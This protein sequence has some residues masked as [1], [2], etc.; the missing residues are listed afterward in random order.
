MIF[1]YKENKIV[2]KNGKLVISTKNEKCYAELKKNGF[3]TYLIQTL[4]NFLLSNQNE[5]T[6]IDNKRKLENK[7][8]TTVGFCYEE[9]VR[10]NYYTYKFTL[11]GLRSYFT[12]KTNE[13]LNLNSYYLLT[14]RIIKDSFYNKKRTTLENNLCYEE[15][16]FDIS[17]LK[18]LE[19]EEEV[20]VEERPR[21]ELH[22]HTTFSQ[23]DAFITSKQ[24]K[25]YFDK[26][27]LKTLAITDHGIPNSF[28][29]SIKSFSKSKD[30][31]VI[32]AIELYVVDDKK[33]NITK[34]NWYEQFDSCNEQL[35]IL[36]ERQEELNSFIEDKNETIEETKLKQNELKQ[37]VSDTEDKE[38][39]KELKVKA[40]SLREFMLLQKNSLTKLKTELKELKIKI[41]QYEEQKLELSKSE[42][43][44]GDATRFHVSIFVKSKDTVYSDKEK[45][46]EFDYNPGIYEL[47]KAI[48]KSFTET[49]G[50][51]VLN[52]FLGKRNIVCLSDLEKLKETGY[53]HISG[54]CSLGIITNYL[55]EKK[56]YIADEYAYLFDSIEL[57]P[58]TNNYY[59][60]SKEEYP[61][62][63][64][65][66]DLIDLNHRIYNFG[67]KHGIKVI[68]TSDAHVINKEERFKRAIYKKSYFSMLGAKY[69]EDDFDAI[70]FDSREE[71]QPFLHKYSEFV[72]ELKAQG[73][74]EAVIEE[75]Y[76]NE[77]E[78]SES[79]SYFNNITVIPKQMFIPKVEGIDNLKEEITKISF[80]K[81]E[82]MYG[83]PLHKEIADRLQNEID[84]VCDAGYGY[85]Y[86]VSMNLVKESESLGYPVGSRGSV[87][88][89]ILALFMGITENN[90]LP[91]HYYCN[92]GFIEWND[93]VKNGLDLENML[94]PKCGKQL[95]K[96]GFGGDISSFLGKQKVLPDGTL[97]KPK[98]PD[99]D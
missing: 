3:E 61:D 42:P 48:T 79:L 15:F 2:E 1:E 56:E 28:P 60:L 91:P 94:C 5:L 34:L 58:L 78:I 33:L 50:T 75:L 71:V 54:A 19:L 13:A 21:Y 49:Y 84:L 98:T 36:S 53:F 6:I 43:A 9:E 57:Q 32:P 14:G 70:L 18:K 82:E 67:K 59:L 65:K 93:N 51:P 83:A 27:Y 23:R 96:N 72:S 35:S 68:F 81:A 64:T 41:K 11:E 87:G 69:R 85:C 40:S 12:V 90:A 80:S 45:G 16:T 26:G 31:N 47:N 17:D 73:F 52:K 39:K 99:I 44:L 92:C 77:K 97:S 25:E 7:L 62:Y 4:K 8:I 38:L 76:Q 37:L 63:K 86:Y 20:I 89:S 88:S 29:E 46:Y 55:I 74:D 95:K 66:Q 22:L 24:I 10:N 30:Y